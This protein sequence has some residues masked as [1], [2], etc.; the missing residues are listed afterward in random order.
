MALLVFLPKRPLT[1]GAYEASRGEDSM[2]DCEA[3]VGSYTWRNAI[4]HSPPSPDLRPS[5]ALI[6]VG[7]VGAGGVLKLTMLELLSVRGAVEK[8]A[9][10]FRNGSMYC[11]S[12]SDIMR[13]K[14]AKEM[15]FGREMMT[16]RRDTNAAK[17]DSTSAATSGF[18]VSPNCDILCGHHPSS[19]KAD[20]AGMHASTYCL[21]LFRLFIF[22]SHCDI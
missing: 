4:I 17:I 20:G 19:Q 22:L 13:I 18:N 7:T 11:G 9:K 15:T 8:E 16:R 5:F 10:K 6:A 21:L 3:F 14:T 2:F 1:S 12:T